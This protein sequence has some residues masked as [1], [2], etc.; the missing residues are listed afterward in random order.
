M[1]KVRLI[2]TLIVLSSGTAI[3][4]SLLVAADEPGADA[5]TNNANRNA[6]VLHTGGTKQ[7]PSE[8]AAL[9]LA[10]R[11]PSPEPL[12]SAS[13]SWHLQPRM[14]PGV[15]YVPLEQQ[16]LPDD[17]KK[18]LRENFDRLRATGSSSGGVVT[19]EFMMADELEKKL[20][21]DGLAKIQ[22]SLAITPSELG[23]ALDE[24]FR[25]TGADSQGKNVSKMGWAGFFQLH[26][27]DD[28]NR[29]V[30]LSENQ[31]ESAVGDATVFAP[32]LLNERVL[33]SPAS[34]ESLRDKDGSWLFNLQW[35][36]K[37]RVFHLTTRNMSRQ[38]ATQLA[39]RV[40]QA[41]LAM[42]NDGWR[43]PYLLDPS[44]NFHQQLAAQR[45]ASAS[46]TTSPRSPR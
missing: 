26:K 2:A 3:A 37:D 30:E 41:F 33:D 25:L 44:N 1:V 34:I 8:P 17:V 11:A 35:A 38:E 13:Q 20:R 15:S 32:E 16:A 19:H 46:N 43:T 27:S 14:Q 18:L 40:T 36:A 10:D 24:S 29:W 5:T 39:A 21:K 4:L 28:G 9:V 7:T 45:A 31:L 22:A 23:A 6:Q 12:A 42:P